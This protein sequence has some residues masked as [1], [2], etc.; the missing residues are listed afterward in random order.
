VLRGIPIR[1][2]TTGSLVQFGW[3]SK[4]RRIQA[5]EVDR[6]SAVA[7]AI[8]QDKELTKRLLQ[9]AGVPVPTGRP[10]TDADDAWAAA[11]EVGLPVGLKPRD[12]NQGK[13]VTV[14]VSTRA[15]LNAAYQTAAAIGDVLVER[16]LPGRDFRLLVV[17]DRLIAA[18]RRDPPQVIGDGEHTVQQ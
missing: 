6:T 2:L 16:F 3:G 1:R 12:G 13:G 7:E 4:A 5:A 17:G 11:I 10:V 8:A 9:A 18:S 15:Q 14:N